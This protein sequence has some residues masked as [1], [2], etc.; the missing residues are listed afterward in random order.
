M[1]AGD[2]K[3]AVIDRHGAHFLAVGGL[4]STGADERERVPGGGV[5][6]APRELDAGEPARY[7]E[8]VVRR[9]ELAMAHAML[10]GDHSSDAWQLARCSARP[11]HNSTISDSPN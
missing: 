6:A 7:R 9:S 11:A 4:P 3:D 5:P 10:H 2:G 1:R 8:G